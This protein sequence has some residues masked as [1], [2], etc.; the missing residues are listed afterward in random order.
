MEIQMEDIQKVSWKFKQLDY[1]HFM[2]NSH[3]GLDLKRLL[4]EGMEPQLILKQ[5]GVRTMIELA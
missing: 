4:V 5:E 3:T 2:R 1:F